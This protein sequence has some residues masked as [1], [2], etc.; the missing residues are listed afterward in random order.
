MQSVEPSFLEEG[1]NYDSSVWVYLFESTNKVELILFGDV[2][3][4]TEATDT[5][6]LLTGL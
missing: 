2:I 4:E 6:V 1:E 5:W 3:D